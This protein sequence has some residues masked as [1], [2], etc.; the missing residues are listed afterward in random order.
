MTVIPAIDL[1]GGRC[2][3]LRQGS[4]SDATVYDADPGEVARSFADAGAERIHLVDL[5]AARSAGDNRETIGRIRKTVSCSLE[6]GGGV[7]DLESLDALLQI[8]VDYVILGTVLARDP[9]LVARWA[10]RDQR[11]SRMLASIDARD[12]IVQIAGW[13]EG[14]GI[15]ARDL[16]VK[17]AEIGLAAVE[18]TNI[19]RDGMLT[20]PD[21]EGTREIAGAVSIPVILSGG[22]A[23]TA[24]TE[25]IISRGG[26]MIA[27]FIVGRALYEGSFDLAAAIRIAR[28]SSA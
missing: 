1:I 20:G 25:R 23:G 7:R 6:V 5:D 4:Y 27:G 18:Y 12:G 3:R 15:A 24:D 14:S 19:A 16:A 9:D 13:Q 21:I 17:A 26:G 8:G 10:A 11:G 22:I 28:G 2:V